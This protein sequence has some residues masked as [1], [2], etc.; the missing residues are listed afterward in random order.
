MSDDAF[1]GGPVVGSDTPLRFLPRALRVPERPFRALALAWLTTFPLSILLAYLASR[2]FPGSAQPDF[3]ASGGLAIFALV[4]FSP[5]IETLIMGGVLLLLLRFLPET[6][7]I[8][9][10][11]AGWG[12]AHSLMAPTW[13]L[14]IWWPFL[15]FSTLFVAWRRRSLG[16]AFL[17]PM[18]A[19]ALQNLLPA[20]LIASGK[21]L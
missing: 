11:A 17:L 12:I 20:I 4:I 2:L 9:V 21:S 3:K 7:A 14:A 10:S 6:A 19:H 5:V 18:G 15:I 8:L 1:A 13:G 16:L